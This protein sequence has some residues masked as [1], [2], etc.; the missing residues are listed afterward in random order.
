MFRLFILCYV[1]LQTVIVSQELEEIINQQ[2]GTDKFWKCSSLG[3]KPGCQCFPRDGEI[4]SQCSLPGNDHRFTAS[5]NVKEASV[6]IDCEVPSCNQTTQLTE[7]VYSYLKAISTRN[8]SKLDFNFCPLPFGDL[9]TFLKGHL[10]LTYIQILS[11]RS[12]APIPTLSHDS[13]HSLSQL[14]NLNLMNNYIEYLPE[15]IFENQSNLKKLRLEKNNLK[16]INKN[17][18]K[19][20][21]NLQLLML[22]SNQ[23]T[24]LDYLAFSNLTNLLQLN[25]QNN[26]LQTLPSN[27]LQSMTNLIILDLS[28]NR[29]VN[30]DE[31]TF[32]HNPKLNELS[33]R[34]NSFEVLSAGVFK[35]S[36]MLKK[37]S[38]Q[39]NRKLSTVHRNVF[40]N[41]VKLQDLDLS[42]CNLDQSSLENHIFQNL[43][44]LNKLNLAGNK[45]SELNP[46]WF[47]G[48][49][50]LTSLDISNNQLTSIDPNTFSNL[51]HLN[52]LKLNENRLVR[53]EGNVFKGIGAL[54]S[55]FLQGNQL[56]QITTE[57]M[58]ELTNLELINLSK[59]RLKFDEGLVSPFDGRRQSPLKYNLMLKSIDL[60]G[61]IIAEFFSDWFNFKSLTR[62][63]LSNNSF[64]MLAI[65]DLSGFSPN[66]GL[67][68]D[69]RDNQIEQLRFQWTFQSE[70][71]KEESFKKKL[72]LDGNPLVCDCMTYFAVQ[73]M[74]RSMK[75]INHYSWTIE[76]PMLTCKKPASLAGLKPT[77]VN[78][79]L[80]VCKCKDNFWPC[81]CYQRPRDA[82]LLLECQQ[83]NLTEIPTR[84]PTEPGYKVQMNLSSNQ[85]NFG[86]PNLQSSN[87]CAGVV[88]LDLSYN[89]MNSSMF[90]IL[91]WAQNLRLRFPDLTRLDLTH[92]NFNYVPTGIVETWNETENLTYLLS[93]NPWSCDCSN[94]DLL[95]FLRVSWRRVEDL[96]QMVCWNGIPV[97]KSFDNFCSV[98]SLAKYLSIAMPALALIIFAICV[99]MYRSRRTIL[100][101]LYTHKL[102]MWC[103]VKEDDD[104][105][106]DDERVYDAF[107]SYSHLDEEFVIKELVPQ[108]ENPVPGSPE[109]RLCLH[110]R[111]WYIFKISLDFKY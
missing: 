62:L 28:N 75:G 4:F 56:E 71:E 59:N 31:N 23:I 69:L 105:D 83:K 37:L 108:L 39:S 107:V 90:D 72:L 19:N 8:I 93:G 64:P 73:Y 102:C 5:Y 32:Q 11:I 42:Q 51:Q 2:T 52:I 13:F 21:I 24:D 57:A 92:N 103:V 45:L 78:P 84:L 3:D 86:S 29:L 33:L 27:V 109:Y 55:L 67:S 44:Q 35:H 17:I 96:N 43:S 104:D 54:T 16:F 89:Q 53:L 76:A 48:L 9:S 25:L 81:D 49:I 22:G 47:N 97:S 46:D 18:F 40:D 110:Y 80:F 100:A 85:I 38:L 106:E 87:C 91:G 61:N 95:N 63:L 36:T 7:S 30:L 60:S 66:G 20:L 1:I 10:N 50:T 99:L 82:K 6:T 12:C 74:N 70:E 41:L 77:S 58:K 34:N 14:S 26:F 65:S 88:S 98:N 79:D 111:D 68:I 101:W 15:N 94:V